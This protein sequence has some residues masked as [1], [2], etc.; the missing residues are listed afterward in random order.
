MICVE[1]GRQAAS[2]LLLNK[3]TNTLNPGIQA[4]GDTVHSFLTL[5]TI[6]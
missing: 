2:F 4:A 5:V 6:M 1:A 3:Q